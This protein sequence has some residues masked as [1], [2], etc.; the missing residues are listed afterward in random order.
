MV[1]LILEKGP[2]LGVVAGTFGTPLHL[3]AKKGYRREVK[4]LL[5]QDSSELDMFTVDQE[6]RLP[7]HMAVSSSGY[8][9]GFETILELLCDP[10]DEQTIF[11]T[12]DHQERHMA[13][14]GAA[15]GNESALIRVL[16][17]NEDERPANA[18]SPDVDGWTPLH[19]ACR[20]SSLET[21]TLL[22]ENGGDQNARTKYGWTPLDVAVY[23]G[24]QLLN[25]SP[26]ALQQLQP[27]DQGPG[28]NRSPISHADLALIP[29]DDPERL[30]AEETKLSYMKDSS[31]FTGTHKYCKSCQVNIYG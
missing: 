29:E 15:A 8:F 3:A 26:Q 16:G 12:T 7:L 25:N 17:E 2:N 6:G 11:M 10:H 5:D 23:H 22:L 18:H 30:P 21:I 4:L 24:R 28:A 20:Q 13:H 27:N 9:G 19:W 14:F 31:G 1:R